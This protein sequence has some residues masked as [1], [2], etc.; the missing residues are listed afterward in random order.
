[1]S[2][3][4]KEPT[5]SELPYTPDVRFDDLNG[6]VKIE[7]HLP[8]GSLYLYAKIVDRAEG[9]APRFSIRLVRENGTETTSSEACNKVYAR[10]FLQ[11]VVFLTRNQA[12]ELLDAVI[13]QAEN[14][15]SI[16]VSASILREVK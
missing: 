14:V 1:M 5:V 6:A 3:I 8:V 7:L 16:G 2:N 13:T 15:Y 12:V 9:M 10:D 4:T 11:D